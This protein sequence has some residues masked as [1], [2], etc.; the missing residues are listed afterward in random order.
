MF[1]SSDRE[2]KR[3]EDAPNIPRLTKPNQ[4]L[5]GNDKN[6]RIMMEYIIRKA[7]SDNTYLNQILQELQ[8]AGKPY[9]WWYN[10]IKNP[11]VS[12]DE[13][14]VDHNLFRNFVGHKMLNI[15]N[16]ASQTAIA[17]ALGAATSEATLRHIRAFIDRNK[18][19]YTKG[20]I[21]AATVETLSYGTSEEEYFTQEDT[22]KNYLQPLYYDDHTPNS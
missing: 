10:A 6:A 14:S 19:F 2:S 17:S 20:P 16:A 5:Y 22:I 21:G 15:T 13:K 18:S 7:D 9:K 8:D 4:Y 3:G 12:D 11:K 1:S